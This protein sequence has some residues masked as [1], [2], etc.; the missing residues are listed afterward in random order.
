MTIGMC[1]R[2]QGPTYTD[3]PQLKII[4]ISMSSIGEV[5]QFANLTEEEFLIG[6]YF[7]TLGGSKKALKCRMYEKLLLFSSTQ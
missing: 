4:F 3:S 7:S 6:I 5:F 1:I 2:P